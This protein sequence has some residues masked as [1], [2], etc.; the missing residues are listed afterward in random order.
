MNV[1]AKKDF[2]W[3]HIITPSVRITSPVSHAL[4]IKSNPEPITLMTFNRRIKSPQLPP[5]RY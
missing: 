5:V 3:N 2:N 1:K 4:E